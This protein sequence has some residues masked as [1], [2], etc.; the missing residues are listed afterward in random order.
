MALAGAGAHEG[1]AA[2]QDGSRGLWGGAGLI[3][4]C[5]IHPGDSAVGEDLPFSEHLLPMSGNWLQTIGPTLAK[6]RNGFVIRY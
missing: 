5:L 1:W 2:N 4:L 6:A 3:L